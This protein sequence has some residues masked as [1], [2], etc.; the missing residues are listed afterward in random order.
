[1]LISSFFKNA[2]V[3][4]DS[5]TKTH[6]DPKPLITANATWVTRFSD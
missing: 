3:V 2:M 6:P 1:L 5:G 4:V